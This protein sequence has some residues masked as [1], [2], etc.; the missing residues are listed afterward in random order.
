MAMKGSIYDV[1]YA[2]PGAAK[3]IEY[4]TAFSL[5]AESSRDN[6]RPEK[7]PSKMNP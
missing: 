7:I 3:G 4:R 6:T 2:R 1:T 5:A